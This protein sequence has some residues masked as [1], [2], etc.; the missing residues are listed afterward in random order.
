MKITEVRVILT[1]PTRNYLF[2][3]IMTDEGVYGVGEG[4]L[5]GSEL[6]VAT[7]IEHA[8]ELLIGQ[9]PMRTE[10]LWQLVY[11][12]SYWRGGPIFMAALGALDLALWDIK[13]KVANLP[14]Y[15]LLGGRARDGVLTYGHAGGGSFREVED[16]VRSFQERGYKVIRAQMGGYGG[17]GMVKHTPSPGRNVPGTSYFH[18]ANYLT[19]TPKMFEHLRV[20]LG[21]TVELLH[22]VH[23][24]LAPIETGW[25]ARHLEPYRLFYL[26][27]ILPPE[28]WESFRVVRDASKTSLAI[29][30][31]FTSRWDCLRL[32]QEQLIDFIRIKPIH[33]GGI[34]EARKI[35][36]FAEP[37]QI[38]S[39]FHGAAD[40]GPIGQASSLHLQLTIPNF[41]VQE[42]SDFNAANH[43]RLRE[44]VPNPCHW[45]DGFARPHEAPGLGMDVNE[46]AAKKYPYR[47][48]F[49]PIVRRA[50]GTMH[51]Y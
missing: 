50:D 44:V 16:S 35:M 9:D 47:R 27:D 21:D 49:M 28:H 38:R 19:E 34:T 7:A 3:K 5:N 48:A 13:G 11:N 20:A 4:T 43:E 32:F 37:A 36:V 51:R 41:G 22:D 40:I 10:D 8:G 39:A 25:L 2:V 6:A 45:E 15:Q 18:A 26:E 12:W 33:V 24:Q 23:E 1:C 17:T 31:I 42:W 29:G 30:E 46:N 14:V